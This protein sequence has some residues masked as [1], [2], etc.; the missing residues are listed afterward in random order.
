MTKK[1]SIGTW[2]YIFN[3]EKP[4]NDFHEA[5]HKLDKPSEILALVKAVRDDRN[6]PNFGVLFDTCHAHLCAAV[7]ANQIGEKETLP[8]GALGLLK[9]LKGKITHV[10]LIDSDGKLNKHNT[11]E[12]VPFGQGVLDFDLRCEAFRG[13]RRTR[14]SAKPQGDFRGGGRRGAR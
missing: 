13:K 5:L 8:G 6:N 11:S 14:P 7:G 12:H 1:L 10:D 4:T 3:Q 2:A 9:K